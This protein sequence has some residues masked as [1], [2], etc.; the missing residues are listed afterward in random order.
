MKFELFIVLF[1]ITSAIG[2]SSR[3]KQRDVIVTDSA[4]SE[5]IILS[6]SSILRDMDKTP[7]D[8][9]VE[10]YADSVNSSSS[11]DKLPAFLLETQLDYEHLGIIS[12]FHSPL[13]LRK[14][15]FD[16]VSNCSSLKLILNEKSAI[17]KEKP[18][19][20]LGIKVDFS[21]FSIYDLA[22]R[23]SNELNCK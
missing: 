7:L 3:E 15:I 9:V 20:H 16:K 1:S 14:L 4:D 22:Y 13:P 10:R 12:P 8:L 6:D 17:Y 21:D 2:C 19:R 5:K 23:R 18:K 11:A